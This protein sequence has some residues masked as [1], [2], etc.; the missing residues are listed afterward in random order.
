MAFMCITE[1]VQGWAVKP[2]II[3]QYRFAHDVT[4]TAAMV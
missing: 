3:I 1:R 4:N 2:M